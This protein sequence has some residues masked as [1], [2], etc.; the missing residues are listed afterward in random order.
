LGGAQVHDFN[1]GVEQ[2]GLFW[3][4]ILSPDAVQVDLTAGTASL[5]AHDLHMKD[6][7]DFENSVTGYLGQ[8]PAPSVVSFRVEWTAGG[9][10]HNFNNAAQKFRGIFRDAAA[11]MQYQ[12]RTADFDIASAPLAASTPLAGELG[13]E[14]NGSFY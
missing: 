1:P 5:E 11:K 7:F 3:T 6:Y 2:N 10:V 4:V 14:S 12:I 8:T 13:Q 9:P